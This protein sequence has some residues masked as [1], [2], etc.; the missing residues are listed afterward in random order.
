MEIVNK[1]YVSTA[2]LQ[3]HVTHQMTEHFWYSKLNYSGPLHIKPLQP[4]VTSL[5]RPDFRYTQIVKYKY[6]SLPPPESYPS[7]K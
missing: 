7:Y 1:I 6:V 3:M 4:K 2:K 5:I